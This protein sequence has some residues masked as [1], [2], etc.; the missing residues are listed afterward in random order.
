MNEKE[1]NT[2]K[3]KL[4]KY[5]KEADFEERIY[6][7]CKYKNPK[8]TKPIN[9]KLVI[10]GFHIEH[11]IYE[12]PIWKG[13]Q[14]H[15]SSVDQGVEKRKQSLE[16]KK[17]MDKEIE[18]LIKRHPDISVTENPTAIAELEKIK[19]KYGEVLTRREDNDRRKIRSLKS[20]IQS[21]FDLWT[22][23]VTLTFKD[24]LYDMKKAKKHLEK[25]IEKM[26]ILYPEFK[27]VYVLEFQKRGA[28]HF[29]TLCSM[30]RGRKVSKEKFKK[31]TET[32]KYG[33]IDIAGIN[34]KYIPKKH[35]KEAEKELQEL[36]SSDKLK[37]IWSVGNYLTSYLKKGSDSVLLF[38]S[39]MYGN[40]S[41]L[42]EE[43]VIT[44]KEKIDQILGELG[45]D[46]L[47]K[48]EYKISIDETNNTVLKNFYNVLI[49]NN[50]LEQ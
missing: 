44:D 46:R 42:K 50:S 3:M 23:F 28:C 27:Y 31:T 33:N 43:I 30:D 1:Q 2:Y 9:E 8:F 38:G 49:E 47:K 40:S 14:R 45:V 22:H 11:S 5:E 10:S 17:E 29:H 18:D 48:N 12:N 7:K 20:K 32:W 6:Q 25:W 21:N 35:V 41:D 26:K 37:T 36:S 24:N 34:Y 4:R 15:K 19:K 13:M 16:S 39:K